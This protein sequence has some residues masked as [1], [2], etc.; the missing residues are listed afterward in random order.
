MVMAIMASIYLYNRLPAFLTQKAKTELTAVLNEN[1]DNLYSV[2]IE[3]IM[4]SGFFRKIH[5]PMLRIIPNEEILSNTESAEL[6][7]AIIRLTLENIAFSSDGLIDVA[8]GKKAI[9]FDEIFFQSGNITLISNTAG[10]SDSIPKTSENPIEKFSVGELKA[11]LLHFKQVSFPDTTI[12]AADSI[13]IIAGI[14]WISSPPEDKNQIS[15]SNYNLK[16]RAIA[17]TPNGELYNYQVGDLY[18]S[19]TDSTLQINNFR[20]FPIHKKDQLSKHMTYQADVVDVSIKTIAFSMIDINEAINERAL[21]SPRLSI[22]EG[23]VDVFR[24]RNLPL[25]SLRRPDMPA[26]LIMRAA[27][28]ILIDVVE[29]KNVD[30]NYADL[31][32]NGNE[33]GIVPILGING[34]IKNITNI[35]N[36]LRIDSMMQITATARL[37]DEARL[38]ASFTYNLRDINGGFIARGTL[39]AI[40]F[41]SLNPVL[42]ALL[43]VEVEDGYHTRNQFWF[44]GNDFNTT[45]E[46]T[47]E[48]NNLRI[49]ETDRSNLR[50]ALVGWAGRNFLYHPSNPGRN[51]ALRI[52]TI[53]F[54]R[55]PSRFVIHYWWQ[56]YL[57]GIKSSILRGD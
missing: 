25:D 31:P 4:L 8:R 51:D 42:K 21:K 45:G 36:N 41:K 38:D 18:F 29:I 35:E 2:E 10:K 11:D 19:H 46:I 40:D 28:P 26:K 3:E 52:G 1:H 54:S 23:M 7:P 22:E 44:S 24:D 43:N 57:S 20:L 37:F 13:S 6:P 16:T 12:L 5:I 15:I 32:A 53:D 49:V 17:V 50:Q 27:V 47:M 33:E 30:L 48:Y 14:H 34:T 9:A 55:D 56:S 39:G